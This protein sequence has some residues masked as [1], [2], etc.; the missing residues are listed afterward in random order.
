MFEVDEDTTE[1]YINYYNKDHV[2]RVTALNGDTWLSN[3]DGG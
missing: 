3:M 2:V 1:E